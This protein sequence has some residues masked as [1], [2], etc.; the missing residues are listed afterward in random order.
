D[1]V[2]GELLDLPLPALGSLVLDRP[3]AGVLVE[4]DGGGVAGIFGCRVRNQSE[5]LGALATK[6]PAASNDPKGE[7]R[8]FSGSGRAVFGVVDDWLLVSND[9]P[10]LRA[11]ALFV[12]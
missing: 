1:L 8:V 3:A 11:A 7:L 6:V 2:L 4:R 9:E 12:A 10:A 5:V